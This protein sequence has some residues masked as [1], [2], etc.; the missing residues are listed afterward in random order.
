MPEREHTYTHLQ[1]TYNGREGRRALQPKTLTLTAGCPLDRQYRTWCTSPVAEACHLSSGRHVWGMGHW[2]GQTSSSIPSRSG[3]NSWWMAGA[4]PRAPRRLVYPHRAPGLPRFTDDVGSIPSLATSHPDTAVEQSNNH[5]PE[6]Y[7]A[8]A[9]MI[10]D[11][12]ARP[13]WARSCAPD[14]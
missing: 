8:V 12:T 4:R 1:Y 10:R 7:P 5:T 14:A 6:L 11:W 3:V 9:M 13:E 2:E